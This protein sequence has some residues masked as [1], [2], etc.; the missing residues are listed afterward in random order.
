MNHSY[1]ETRRI[2][3]GYAVNKA[4]EEIEF[5]W[6]PEE[7]MIGLLQTF[8]KVNELESSPKMLRGI[9]FWALKTVRQA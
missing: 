7:R 3:E 5:G 6:V 1:K 9:A 4:F 8:C 2:L